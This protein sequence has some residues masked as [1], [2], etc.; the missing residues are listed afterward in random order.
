MINVGSDPDAAGDDNLSGRAT[1]GIVALVSGD[2]DS[3]GAAAAC[4]I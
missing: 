2:R 4:V 1:Y 3:S